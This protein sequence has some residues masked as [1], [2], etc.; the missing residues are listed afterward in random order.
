MSNKV[1]I[2]VD[3]YQFLEAYQKTNA[4]AVRDAFGRI[5][6][7]SVW[8]FI[9][10]DVANKKAAFLNKMNQKLIVIEEKMDQLE[11]Q[12]H[13]NNQVIKESID[14]TLK[15]FEDQMETSRRM[16]LQT[17]SDL[18]RKSGQAVSLQVSQI[19]KEMIE[20]YQKETSAVIIDLKNDVQT[21]WNRAQEDLNAIKHDLAL[22]T[23]KS[24]E[25]ARAFLNNADEVYKELENLY[26][27]RYNNSKILINLQQDLQKCQNNIQNGLYETAMANA[28]TLQTQCYE[29]MFHF[30]K[31]RQEYNAL[32]QEALYHVEYLLKYSEERMRIKEDVLTVVNEMSD[33]KKL[34][35][36]MLRKDLRLFSANQS[37]DHYLMILKDYQEKLKNQDYTLLEIKEEIEVIREL[38]GK[39]DQAFNNAVAFYGNYLEREAFLNNIID[40]FEDCGR[41]Y[42]SSRIGETENC[43]DYT[44]PIFALFEDESTNSEFMIEI[45]YRGNPQTKLESEFHVHRIKGDEQNQYENDMTEELV[46]KAISEGNEDAIQGGVGCQRDTIG[47]LSQDARILKVRQLM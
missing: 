11:K 16:D 14:R 2:S 40:T 15:D 38:Y 21:T 12:F 41:V 32:M 1:T 29:E 46:K 7:Y 26:D 34:S 19:N 17:M 43:Q 44:Q 30:D 3:D 33:G 47:K 9:A 31:Q 4:V 42:K 20:K 6:G 36:R 37:I 25:Y 13:Q 10:R 24:N 45:N 8:D 27:Q 28:I 5:I 18:F 22:K 35:K 23:T 39:I